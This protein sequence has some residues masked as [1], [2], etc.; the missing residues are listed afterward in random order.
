MILHR[1]PRERGQATVEF[2]LVLP[3]VVALLLT[4]VQVALVARAHV[5]VAGAARDAARVAAVDGHPTRARDAAVRGSGL[6]PARLEVQV[7][8]GPELVT[9]QVSYRDPT[10][11][12]LAGRLVGDVTV[13]AKVV[14]RRER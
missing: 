11:V 2:A 5:L 6:D 10:S 4:V 3:L 9:A 1:R 8:I 13:Q 14:M 12:P 7:Q